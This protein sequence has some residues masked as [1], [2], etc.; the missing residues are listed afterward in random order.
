[1]SE[2]EFTDYYEAL[3]VSANADSET[4]DRVFRHLAKRYHPDNPQTGDSNRFHVLMEAHRTLTDAEKRA[5]YDSHYQQSVAR[6]WSLIEEAGGYASD[7]VDQVL[8]ERLLALLYVQRR[9]D[10]L[11]PSMG[12]IQLEKLLSC[13]P[14]YLEFHIWYLKE[15]QYVERTD[16]GFAITADGIDY[17]EQSRALITAERLLPEKA[18]PDEG[19]VSI[20]P[21]S[22]FRRTNGGS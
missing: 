5:E 8:R 18:S 4:I 12:H 1:V 16:Q 22:E 6:Q 20:G 3:Q 19:P 13:P 14:E 21:S 2:S 17:A 10:V 11:N 15:K 9:R 7:E